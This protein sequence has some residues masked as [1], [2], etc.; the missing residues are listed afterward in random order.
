MNNYDISVCVFA[1]N[2]AKHINKCI[3]SI[4]MQKTAFTFNIIL[5]ED[6]STDE[7]REI[8]QYYK[9]Q[10]PNKI[11]LLDR[12]RNL[13]QVQNYYDTINN[14]TGKYVSL[15]DAD[16]F[17]I[18][19]LK[20]N[21]QVSYLEKNQNVSITFHNA[22]VYNYEIPNNLRLFNADLHKPTI[23]NVIST[24]LMATSTIVFRNGILDFPQWVYETS[25]PDLLIQLLLSS[26][27]DIVYFKEPMGVYLLN[28]SG[29]TFNKNYNLIKNSK[30]VIDL[31]VKFNNYTNLK[32]NKI[33]QQ[34]IKIREKEIKKLG[35]YEKFSFLVSFPKKINKILI[36]T[37]RLKIILVKK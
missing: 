6:Y 24:W 18:D 2:K 30:A 13:G 32:Y 23:K 10:Y 19:P 17:W 22:F 34:T 16:D 21:K 12:K 7:T 1:Y 29:L 8:C 37:F 4:L 14:A 27:G 3:E 36:K 9:S 35:F 31:L 26:V 5:G 28:E 33:V 20:L 25:N 11:I 15:M